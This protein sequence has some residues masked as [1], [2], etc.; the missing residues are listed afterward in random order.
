MTEHQLNIKRR[1]VRVGAL[2]A[3][4]GAV[5]IALGAAAE[6]EPVDI[7]GWER[8][9][10][11]HYDYV[12]AETA[13]LDRQHEPVEVT[14]T[15]PGDAPEEWRHQI[16]VVRLIDGR[17]GVLTPHQELGAV[18]AVTQPRPDTRIP[19]PA[20]SVNV[21]FLARCPAHSEV[22][23]RLFWGLPAA[24]GLGSHTLPTANVENGLAIAGDMPGLT[25]GNEFYT[26]ELDSKS[27]AIRTARMA[28]RG[29][30]TEMFYKTVPIHFGTDIWSPDQNWDHDYDWAQP[31]HQH[32]EGGVL[33]LRYH[34]WGPLEHYRDVVVS[35]TYTFYAH[36]PYVHVSSVMEF[37]AARSAR[38]V[39]VGEIVVSHSRRP[40]SGQA[41]AEPESPEIFSHYAW[42][43]L[44]GSVVVRE[45]NAHRDAE[46][47]ANIEGL[48]A[49]ALAILDRDV[50][51]VAGFH[52]VKAYGLASLRKRQF[53][54]NRAGGPIPH[55]APCTYVANYGWG[56]AYWSRPMVYP[57]G[58]KATAL[59]QN[60]AI[61]AGT[62][63]ATEEALLFFEPDDGLRGLRD[64]HRRFTE[65]VRFRFKGTGPW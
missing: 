14:L 53:A 18:S 32:Q 47:R 42:P 26:V 5:V 34:R 61:A 2:V 39:R 45:I 54:G 1:A 7:A 35:I 13:G 36:V 4:V 43:E 33:A 16:R 23:Y 27:G 56:F 64:A 6:S 17:R 63:F 12:L 20:V 46:G 8:L 21:L 50:P 25:I 9:F 44:D 59:D 28:N 49:G 60:T 22:A 57:L 58:M 48:A 40:E 51:W 31:P 38:A 11:R 10:A 62:I 52:A 37:T 41:E 24:G 15:M 55:S 3:H 65:P 29:K 30:D 19:H